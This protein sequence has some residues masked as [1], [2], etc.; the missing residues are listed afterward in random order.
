MRITTVSSNTHCMVPGNHHLTKESFLSRGFLFQL[1]KLIN[2][3]RKAVFV[4]R[5]N[6]R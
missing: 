6:I 2:L 3:N 4:E 5:W 1:R